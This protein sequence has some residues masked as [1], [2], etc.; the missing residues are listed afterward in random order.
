MVIYM[1]L[2][3]LII[4]IIQKL[5]KI[6]YFT[7]FSDFW[8]VAMETGNLSDCHRLHHKGQILMQ[9]RKLYRFMHTCS[10]TYLLL[11]SCMPACLFTKNH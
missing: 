3:Y 10:P 5:L 4:I 2:D 7:D 6:C 11:V 9:A 8:V 1:G